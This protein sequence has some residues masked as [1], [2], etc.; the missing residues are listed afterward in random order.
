MQWAEC[1]SR[2]RAD[3]IILPTIRRANAGTLVKAPF[4]SPGWIFE[5]L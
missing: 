3:E 1:L 4:D 2:A 5:M